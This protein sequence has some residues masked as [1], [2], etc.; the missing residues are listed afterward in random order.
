MP[1][2]W[3]TFR[4]WTNIQIACRYSF[5]LINGKAYCVGPS[6][7]V[8]RTFRSLHRQC[9]E[10][11]S[12]AS[13]TCQKTCA[14]RPACP[15]RGNTPQLNP[16]KLLALLLLAVCALPAAGAQV[17]IDCTLMADAASDKACDLG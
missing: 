17:L 5:S 7:D 2:P 11:E 15:F 13:Q 9:M 6:Q 1:P 12:R 4:A 8:A 16:R 10:R 14:E 3:A